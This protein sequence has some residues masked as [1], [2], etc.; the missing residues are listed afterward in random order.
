MKPNSQVLKNRSS[1]DTEREFGG[2]LGESQQA[3]PPYPGAIVIQPPIF[4]LRCFSLYITMNSTL[5]RHFAITFVAAKQEKIKNKH[6]LH[7]VH[8]LL[9]LVHT[10]SVCKL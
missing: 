8:A 9:S 2:T 4:C 6:F 3:R 10:Y 5:Y 1:H 7:S